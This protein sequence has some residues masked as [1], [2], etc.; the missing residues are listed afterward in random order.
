MEKP[1]TPL[2]AELPPLVM[3]TATFNGQYNADP[4]ALPTTAL[5]HRALSA[6]IRAFDTSPYYGPAETLLGHAL[7]TAFV[8]ENFPRN[9]YKL[10]TKVGR[11]AAAS[12]DYSPAWIRTSVARSLSRL[13]T[14]Y[15]DLVYCH[16][17]E[18][19]TPDEVLA[20]VCE[21]RR[22]RD[23]EGT[24]R[25]VGISG[26]PVAVLAALAEMVLERTGEP[27]DAVMSYA[28]YTVQNTKLATEGLPRLLAAGVDVVP[29]ASPLGMGLLRREGVP[30][31]SMGDF[32]PAPDGLREAV[33]AASKWTEEQGEKIEVVSIRYALESWLREGSRVGALGAPLASSPTESNGFASVAN[34]G[35]GHRLGASVMGVS[36]LEELDEILR[37]WRS[38]VDGLDSLVDEPL[39]PTRAETNQ[40]PSTSNPDDKDSDLPTTSEYSVS[41]LTP[42][43]GITDPEWSRLRRRQILNLAKGARGV[44]GEW[45]DYTW[46]SP[47]RDFLNVI[48][49]EYRAMRSK[50]ETDRDEASLPTPPLDVRDEEQA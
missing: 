21:L 13:G 6:G 17:V 20:A 31:G 39:D 46:D 32:H 11:V 27:L 16:D 40:L 42:A 49:A 44:I 45:M 35:F 2:S 5:V 1:S 25:Y 4:Y 26:Y 12:F 36:S 29:N 8:R 43:D 23:A 14:E 41:G 7:S 38:I 48:P 15:L 19:V 30:I 3:G 28:N 22:I 50:L 9:T 37:V 18:F 47:G 34:A 10:L 33:H 24:V